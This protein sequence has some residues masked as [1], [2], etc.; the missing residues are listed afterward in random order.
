MKV[1]LSKVVAG[2]AFLS[3]AVFAG[4]VS[5]ALAQA[6][7]IN[8]QAP[9]PQPGGGALTQTGSIF[10]YINALF[11][12]ATG[13]VI[14]FAIIKIMWAGILW[15][16]AGDDAHK[17]EEAKKDILNYIFGLALAVFAYSLLYT[18]NPDLTKFTLN[19]G[20]VTTG[21]G[22]CEFG[23]NDPSCAYQKAPDEGKICTDKSDCFSGL[24]IDSFEGEIGD[25]KG[26]CVANLK[27]GETCENNVLDKGGVDDDAPCP[28][29][30]MCKGKDR[31]GE[32]YGKCLPTADGS[33]CYDESEC[34]SK[35]CWEYADGKSDGI[36]TC[37]SYVPEGGICE[38]ANI[39]FSATTSAGTLGLFSTVGY[40]D[41]P[42]APGL[43]CSDAG[44]LTVTG[45]CVK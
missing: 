40:P 10:T 29:G 5:I 17:I 45:V 6:A 37:V 1:S 16:T 12:F 27:I 30:T 41:A 8:L 18:I 22:S 39:D 9:I 33:I 35:L 21:T 26:R 36:G 11:T 31:A 4:T 20:T 25:K 24:C 2:V 38:D 14:S 32:D 19:V 3:I 7:Q 15:L 43:S 44:I 28:S 23:L 34:D 42:C 13:A